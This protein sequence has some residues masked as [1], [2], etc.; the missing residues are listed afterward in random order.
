M[1]NLLIV[2]RHRNRS[3]DI[4]VGMRHPEMVLGPFEINILDLLKIY[5]GV[6]RIRGAGQSPVTIKSKNFRPVVCTVTPQAH[7]GFSTRWWKS[8]QAV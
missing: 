6:Q 1:G 2:L 5:C 3:K 4:A 8:M 7:L